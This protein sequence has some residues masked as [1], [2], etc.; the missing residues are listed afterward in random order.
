[1]P[2]FTEAGEKIPQQSNPLLISRIDGT[3]R[4]KVHDVNGPI[5][6]L[7]NDFSQLDLERDYLV[8]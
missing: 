4:D 2:A 8:N 6:T 3:V 1:M 5:D 7:G